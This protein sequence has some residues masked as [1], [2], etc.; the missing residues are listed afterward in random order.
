MSE[1]KEKKAADLDSIREKQNEISV[2]IEGARRAM[3]D[4]TEKMDPEAYMDAKALLAEYET[5]SDMYAARQDQILKQEY[6]SEADSDKVIDSLLDYENV[7]A[8]EF[9]ASIAKPLADL[10]SLL[11]KYQQEVDAVERTIADWTYNVHSN[12]RSQVSTYRNGSKRSETPVPVRNI[13]FQGSIASRTINDFLRGP[14]KKYI[15]E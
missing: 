10:N 7:L 2:Q 15:V 5:A 9:E 8:S 6:I 12:Y 4:A 14:A 1:L 11:T 13:P 3:Q